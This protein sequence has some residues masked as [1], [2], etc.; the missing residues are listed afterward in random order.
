MTMKSR[1][2]GLLFAFLPVL[3]FPTQS[4]A[5]SQPGALQGAVV[6]PTGA[7]VPGATVT[8]A[9]GSQTR[10]TKSGPDGRYAFRHLSPGRYS[11]S[12]SAE[13]FAPL[14]ISKVTVAAD[15]TKVLNLPLAIAVQHQQV[16][17][18]STV[19]SVGLSSKH[20]AGETI[21]QGRALHALSDDPS[22]LKSELQALAGPAAGPN[23]GQIYIDGFEGGQIPP[24]S[25][26]LEIR[27]NQNP[28][29]AEYDRI[30]YGRINIIT[31][32]GTLKLHGH[33]STY[34]NSS[35]LNT[36]NP[37]I[38]RQ[39]S[40]YLYAIYGDASGPLTKNASWFF[41][42]MRLDRQEQ[43]VV[44]GLNPQNTAQTL[45]DTFS[46]PS[47]YLSI[48]PRV[49]FQL[50]KSNMFTVRDAYY[51]LTQSGMGVGTLSL[52][53]QARNNVTTFNELQFGETSILNAHFLN[54]THIVWDRNSDSNTP[55]SLAPAVTVQGAFTTG[56]NSA[57]TSSN[58]E[59]VI[60]LRNDST[61]TV[62]SHAMRFGFR[63]RL[64]R[65]VNFSTAGA[66]GS[67]FFNSVTAYHA[68][69]PSQ[70]AATVINNPVARA[71]L[72]DGAIYFQDDWRVSRD[73]ELGMGLRL[74]GQNRIQDHADWAPRL[75]LAWSPFGEH[76]GR[77]KT[78]IRAGYGWF[79]DRFIGPTAFNGGAGTPYIMQAI[80]DNGINEHSYV[81][82]NP[83]FYNP[84]AP[85]PA[86]ALT[87]LPATIPS[88]RTIDPH[89]DAALDMQGG[90]G[91]DRQIAKGIMANVTYL[92][93][94]G[95]HQYLTDNVTAPAF[96]P[97]T[98][99]L[100]GPTP[101][102][103]NYQFQSGGTYK[104]QQLIATISASTRHLVVTGTY[105][106][107]HAMSDTQGV[108]YF[109]S[110]SQDPSFDYG[111]AVFD[112]RNQLMLLDSYTGPYGIVVASALLARSGTPYNITIG[113]DLTGNNQFNARPT[114]GVC[115]ASGVIST[116]FGCL[117]T[118]P[119]GKGEKIVPFDLGTGP[120]NAEIQLLVSKV[121]GVGPR[122]K[123]A[124]KGQSFRAG[125]SSVSGRG[126]SGGGAAIQ[127]EQGTPRRYHLTFL[128]SINNL[129]NM[130]NYGPPD[131]VLLSPLFNKPQSL[132]FSGPGPG[133]RTVEMEVTF[134]F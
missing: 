49:D 128:A 103:F 14:S 36:A 113:N 134:G 45:A 19:R 69:T 34:G 42:A 96:N 127:L 46:T 30:G 98:Y 88:Y 109:P 26:I 51:R 66:N 130:V 9:R 47:T 104:Q 132:T 121:V 112:I 120:A 33:I 86:S 72:F 61:A 105:T 79:Y 37:L 75:D 125:G 31:K 4:A 3:V 68:G 99:T 81:V 11:V 59:D 65:D 124:G 115:G 5:Q 107:N 100:T 50:G 70:Y 106:L 1:V 126:L 13:G 25:S 10:S 21:I 60:V 24:K 29:S 6:D 114:Y 87:S 102:A 2:L 84:N 73:F 97:A 83:T 8:L 20:S 17:V 131:G 94:Q 82:T 35:A 108:N 67:Y 38:A 28:F 16:T 110:V 64:H 77:P 80:H 119:A 117:D 89:F 76:G 23:G 129:F 116:Q 92:Y 18:Q 53:Q 52:P 71:I 58:H 48:G 62:G 41:H 63:L 57:G 85:E 101:A 133:N 39:P 122:L 12:V 56:G 43:T 40:Y 44:D 22:E 78:V 111:R 55:V 32:P 54:E 7:V 95:I 90:I 74:E 91:V 123:R 118:D 15:H 27:V 93:T